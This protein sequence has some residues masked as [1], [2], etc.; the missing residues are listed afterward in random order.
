M[1]QERAMGR[2]KGEPSPAVIDREFP[3]Q[4]S[5][6]D[7]WV[8]GGEFYSIRQFA[9]Q[10]GAASR[11]HNYCHK[12]RWHTVFRFREKAHAEKFKSTYGGDLLDPKTRGRGARWHL[13]RDEKG[14]YN[15]LTEFFQSYVSWQRKLS[16]PVGHIRP[17]RGELKTLADARGYILDLKD[18][19]EKR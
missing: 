17:T 14:R 18:G 2:R 3:H 8:R 16:R 10:L 12:D 1:S 11:N 15:P 9:D 4:I 5:I 7:E 6:P 13:L 19:L